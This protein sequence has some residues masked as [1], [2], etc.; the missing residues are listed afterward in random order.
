MNAYIIYHLMG[1]HTNV[2]GY[3]LVILRC[4]C[5]RQSYCW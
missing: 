3:E 4:H 5:R 2:K 1:S